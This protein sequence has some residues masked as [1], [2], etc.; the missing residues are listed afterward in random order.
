MGFDM[1]RLDQLAT[2]EM[3]QSPESKFVIESNDGIPFLQGCAEFGAIT[4]NFVVS[5]TRPKKTCQPGDILISVRAPVGDLNKADR[6]YCIGRGLA[7]VRFNDGIASNFGW[8][9]LKFWSSSLRIVAQG[10]TFE[11]IGRRE[12]ANLQ[13][14][15]VSLPEQRRIAEI[16]D[17]I[18]EAIQKTEALISKLKA[19]KEGLLHDLLTRGLDKNGKLRD[20]KAHPE[21]FKDSTLGRTPKEWQVVSIGKISRVRRGASPRPIDNPVWFAQEGKG[22]IRISD[23]TR[24]NGLLKETEQYLSSAGVNKSVSVYPGQI[25][26]SICATIGEPI[27]L[28]MNACI[29]DGFVV[30]DQYDEFMCPEFFIHFLRS[31]QSYF[32]SQG[33]TGTQ[34]NLNTNIVK[35]CFIGL[36]ILTEQKNI[37]K[38]LDSHDARI[39]TEEQCSDKLK[40]QKKG[41][42]H[43]LLTG[44][45]RVEV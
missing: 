20:P 45:V 7:A 38:C 11:A 2:F 13:V 34:A 22:W 37:A 35:D 14:T 42:M 36:P 5:C 26:M 15:Y 18:D 31:K 39:R 40:L 8:H 6:E 24:A 19:M 29:H 43:D 28:D 32:R 41:L 12:L 16:L 4:P 9:L 44:K 30:F 1:V 33:Q 25:I 21:Q 27:I 23:V 3:G 10:S 17:T